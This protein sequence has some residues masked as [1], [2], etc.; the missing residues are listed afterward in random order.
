M[1]D[2]LWAW[3]V[4]VFTVMSFAILTD[5]TGQDYAEDDPRWNCFAHGD[6]I[7]AEPASASTAWRAWDKWN[8][9]ADP[10]FDHSRARR[11]E[12]VGVSILTP[13]LHQGQV[14]VS[15]EDGRWYVFS[16]EY[17]D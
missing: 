12:Y 13:A 6:R 11:I 10:R 2:W 9:S 15:W 4:A 17:T 7:C 3:T 5:W 16:A 1:K 14:A 8:V